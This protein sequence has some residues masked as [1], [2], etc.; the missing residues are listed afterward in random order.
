[1]ASLRWAWSRLAQNAHSKRGSDGHRNAVK[2]SRTGRNGVR[3]AEAPAP[4]DPLGDDTTASPLSRHLGHLPRLTLRKARAMWCAPSPTCGP[5][6][7]RVAA[8]A[9]AAVRRA[10]GG[11]SRAAIRA[12]RA[13][14]MWRGAQGGGL[15][16]ARLRSW[17]VS[18]AGIR[19][20]L[21]EWRAGVR[22]GSTP[23]GCAFRIQLTWTG[24]PRTNSTARA[25]PHHSPS[26]RR[27]GRSTSDKVLAFLVNLPVGPHID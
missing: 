10:R 15:G 16:C 19:R 26:G 22:L 23:T 18:A 5:P 4:R 25:Q 17:R 8:V 20:L 7:S 21:G 6:A 12:R 1:M 24:L 9:D 13:C 27:S 14:G 2:M 3:A 11:V